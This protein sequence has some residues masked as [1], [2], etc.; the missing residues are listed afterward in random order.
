MM[1]CGDIWKASQVEPLLLQGKCT[2][3][4]LEWLDVERGRG[5]MKELRPFKLPC[6]LRA[7][8]PSIEESFKIDSS[9]VVASNGGAERL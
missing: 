5:L 8:K 1:P 9:K 4:M 7:F 2:V 3:L 6:Y